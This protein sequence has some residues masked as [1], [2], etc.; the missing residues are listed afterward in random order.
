ME[1]FLYYWYRLFE[2]TG[3]PLSLELLVSMFTPSRVSTAFEP[4]EAWIETVFWVA[5]AD[6]WI[7]TGAGSTSVLPFCTTVYPEAVLSKLI[8]PRE[9]S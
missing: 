7:I 4:E 6:F 3:E 1:A 8:L 9:K 5:L 2:D